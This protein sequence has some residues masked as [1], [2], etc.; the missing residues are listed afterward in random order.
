MRLLREQAKG[1]FSR[2]SRT[3]DL[4]NEIEGEDF[5]RRF[6]S[7]L[8]ETVDDFPVGVVAEAADFGPDSRDVFG[9]EDGVVNARGVCA[10]FEEGELRD[11]RAGVKD[12]RRV[13]EVLQLQREA[14]GEAGMHGRRGRDY[15]PDS[16]PRGAP[17]DGA[18][19]VGGN[20]QVF[21]RRCEKK[22]LGVDDDLPLHPD[23]KMLL[24]L[25]K[26]V[27][28]LAVTRIYLREMGALCDNEL[29]A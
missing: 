8:L 27:Q 10:H 21:Q 16:A 25:I 15:Q 24:R 19:E 28:S 22:L 5:E 3:F 1:F 17:D 4:I 18:G 13:A 2:Q 20:S 7:P 23:I 29:R 14:T 11:A 26:S 12:D 9:S 6:N